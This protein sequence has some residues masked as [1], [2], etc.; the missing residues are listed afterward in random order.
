MGAF[1]GGASATLVSR[2]L[3]TEGLIL[4]LVT[5]LRAGV[6]IRELNGKSRFF[7]DSQCAVNG[8]GRCPQVVVQ[9]RLLHFGRVRSKLRVD[10]EVSKSG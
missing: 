8:Q 9:D 6:T 10:A 1:P 3:E 4:I 7:E 5:V 2:N